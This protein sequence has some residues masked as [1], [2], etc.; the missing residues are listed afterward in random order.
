MFIKQRSNL[1]NPE[2][3]MFRGDNKRSAS[4]EAGLTSP[5]DR[6]KKLPSLKASIPTA[7]KV[8]LFSRARKPLSLQHGRYPGAG[9]QRKEDELAYSSRYELPV[10]RRLPFAPHY[11]VTVCIIPHPSILR[12]LLTCSRSRSALPW[13]PNEQ[14]HAD[15]SCEHNSAPCVRAVN[16]GSPV[17]TWGD[18]IPWL[19]TLCKMAS[20][21]SEQ[22]MQYRA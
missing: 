5:W 19:E 7:F 16:M 6:E 8:S 9:A 22:I 4:K 20:I 14:Q 11:K 12:P 17:G 10:V 3:N 15:L 1:A 21:A 18:E 2:K 13:R